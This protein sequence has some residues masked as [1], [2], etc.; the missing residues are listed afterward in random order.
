MH[1]FYLTTSEQNTPENVLRSYYDAIDF[2]EFER[3]HSYLDPKGGKSINQF[4]LEVSVTDGILSSYA[5]M[6]AISVAISEQTDSSAI[7][8][9]GMQWITPLEKIAKNEIHR[10]I[11]EKGKTKWIRQRK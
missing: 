11:K 7:A 6:D 1:Q 2:K 4:M 3:A 8:N 5:K 10:L 9:V